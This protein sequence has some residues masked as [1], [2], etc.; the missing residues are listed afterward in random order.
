MR[1][2]EEASL[3]WCMYCAC[4][5]LGPLDLKIPAPSWWHQPIPS[6]LASFFMHFNGRMKDYFD[7]SNSWSNENGFSAF[8]C[9]FAIAQHQLTD[10]SARSFWSE[11]EANGLLHVIYL[12]ALDESYDLLDVRPL[13]PTVWY[14]FRSRLAMRTALTS[15]SA[16]RR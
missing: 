7:T 6:A 4:A 16:G 5:Q 10:T 15:P 14:T 8:C 2:G 9:A 13:Q 3:T 1:T 12:T 11:R